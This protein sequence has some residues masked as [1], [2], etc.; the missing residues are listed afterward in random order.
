M[1]TV[2]TRSEHDRE[3]LRYPSDLTD[4][5]WTI[6]EPLFPLPAEPDAGELADA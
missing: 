6:L 1:W 2:N 5:E 4:D 3:D